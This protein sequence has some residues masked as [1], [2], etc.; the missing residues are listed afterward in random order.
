M[1]G[2]CCLLTVCPDVCVWTTCPLTSCMVLATDTLNLLSVSPSECVRISHTLIH[3]WNRQT[4]GA[5][6]RD[7]TFQT[8]SSLTRWQE[9][10]KGTEQTFFVFS[11]PCSSS[12]RSRLTLLTTN[13]FT[14]WGLFLYTHCNP[15]WVINVLPSPM[16]WSAFLWQAVEPSEGLS[17]C[18]FYYFKWL[19][20]FLFCLC[21]FP[22][23]S[24]TPNPHW[25]SPT[26]LH[27]S[28]H[29]LLPL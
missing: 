2:G 17:S 25:L 18:C 1:I 14:Y 5:K 7:E 24:V 8:T 12:L 13:T 19:T 20:H 10:L 3:T 9:A 26:S 28:P 29:P 4:T 11:P 27:L 21:H 23:L 16:C 22:F 6:Q 15:I